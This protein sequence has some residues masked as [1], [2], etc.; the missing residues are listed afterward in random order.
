MA[1]YWHL[2]I[3][4]ILLI[5]LIAIQPI[6]TTKKINSVNWNNKSYYYPKALESPIHSEVE[7]FLNLDKDQYMRIYLSRYPNCDKLILSQIFNYR[8]TYIQWAGNDLFPV[9]NNGKHQ[10]F[11][12]ETNSSPSGQKSLPPSE[13]MSTYKNLIK[14]TFIPLINNSKLPAGYIAVLY[15]TNEMEILGYAQ[16]IKNL[17]GE[18]VYVCDLSNKNNIDSLTYVDNILHIRENSGQWIP[19]R[20]AFRYVT[21]KPWKIIPFKCKTLIFNPIEVC[22]AGGRNK[23][24][25]AIAY[26]E[27]NKQLHKSNLQI[28]YPK[29]MININKQQMPDLIKNVYNGSAVIKVPYSNKGQGVYTILNSNDLDEFLNINH[30]YDNFI[31][32]S[33]IGSQYMNLKNNLYHRGTLP[34]IN[35]SRYIYDIRMLCAYN[36]NKREIRPISLYSR[37]AVS[38]FIKNNAP[39]KTAKSW[40]ILGTNLSYKNKHGIWTT[41][42]D[43]LITMSTKEFEQLN[44]NLTDLVDG[45][46]QTVL[47]MIAIDE[48]AIKIFKDSNYRQM[49]CK[50]NPDPVLLSEI[51]QIN[52]L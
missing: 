15:D 31:V 42:K 38:P 17:T 19:I 4:F 48:M 12:I 25:A 6:I 37:K 46:V 29:T 1:L 43:R 5:I 13:P 7:K 16:M 28:N 34:D 33:L 30:E 20:A 22:F 23:Q 51:M 8:P 3:I 10:M 40:D 26:L 32:Q 24:I 49:L 18:N 27:L 45:Y 52:F 21:Q 11:V 50:L 47:S 44:I 41:D 14:D 36:N 2:L 9:I 39:N 35:G